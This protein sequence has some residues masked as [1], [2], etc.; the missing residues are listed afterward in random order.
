MRT[1][2]R[3]FVLLTLLVILALSVLSC[4]SKNSAELGAPT[5]TVQGEVDCTTYN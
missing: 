4:K 3:T 2:F 1:Y 5:V